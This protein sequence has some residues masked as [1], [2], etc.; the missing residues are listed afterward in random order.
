MKLCTNVIM[1]PTNSLK[2]VS[3]GKDKNQKNLSDNEAKMSQNVTSQFS[4]R[5][6]RI[7][8]EGNFRISFLVTLNR[9]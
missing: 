8:F 9:G 5:V 2:K 3:D 7:E 6:T 1:E 4:H